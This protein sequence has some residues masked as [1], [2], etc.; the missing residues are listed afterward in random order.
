MLEIC[1]LTNIPKND[2]GKCYKKMQKL[3]GGDQEEV[4]VIREKDFMARFCS[5]LGLPVA[6]ERA[7]FLLAENAAKLGISQAKTPI[8]RTAA[9]IYLI[10]Q[11]SDMPKSPKE[12]AQVCGVAEVTLKGAYKEFYESRHELVPKDFK[13]TRPIDSLPDN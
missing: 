7:A 5:N 9:A 1:A 3:L 12:V 4:G 13:L 10:T 11:L 8:S 6:L 2:I